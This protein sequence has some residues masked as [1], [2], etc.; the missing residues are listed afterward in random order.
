MGLYLVEYPNLT[1]VV[2][3]SADLDR[4]VAELQEQLGKQEAALIELQVA[5]D[6]SRSFFIVEAEREEI[7]TQVLK[8]SSIKG[9]KYTD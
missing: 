2:Q 1:E 5:K 3:S 8:D 9:F 4:K 7:A 6:F